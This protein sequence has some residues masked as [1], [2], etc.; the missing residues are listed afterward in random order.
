MGSVG[1]IR[2]GGPLS[3]SEVVIA[4]VLA[5]VVVQGSRVAAIAQADGPHPARTL[6]PAGGA[7]VVAAVVLTLGLR[8][9]AAVTALVAAVVTVDGYLLI[10]FPYGPVQACIVVA[11]FEVARRRTLRFSSL[12]CGLAA[13]VTAAA[14]FARLTREVGSPWL[15]AVAWTGWLI[16]P[17]SLGALVQTVLLNRERSRRHL[18]ARGALEER[19]KIAGEV[20]DVAGH[21]FALVA[22]QAG[23]ALLV[24]DEKPEQAR[25]SLEAI[26]TT[27]AKS[28]TAVR[29]MLDTFPPDDRPRPEGGE[30]ASI[31]AAGQLGLAGLVELIDQ[32][33]AGGLPVRLEVTGLERAPAVDV[34]VA[35]YRV[36]QEALT[37]VLRHAGPTAAEVSVAQHGE[38]LIVRVGDRGSGCPGRPGEG[39]GVAGMRRRVTAAGGSFRSGP[40]DGGGFQVEACLPLAPESR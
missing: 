29:G 20:H 7:L 35:A 16:V 1:E 14:V 11:M 34:D 36:V 26:R 10:G 18:L 25:R 39:R 6:S 31:P 32:V 30:P 5:A 13:L 40:R 37:N 12:V 19:I 21:G 3:R 9:R 8:R 38:E 27:S 28:L 33:R 23:V 2:T 17:W 22:M 4:V 24:L 15:L